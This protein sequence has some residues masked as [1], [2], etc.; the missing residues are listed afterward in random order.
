M[1]PCPPFFHLCCVLSV[2][3]VRQAARNIN[4]CKKQVKK[5]QHRFSCLED[6]FSDLHL[7]KVFF[8]FK[9]ESR[10]KKTLTRGRL[11]DERDVCVA[12]SPDETVFEDLWQ[13]DQ[14]SLLQKL[15]EM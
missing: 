1:M 14:M 2:F 7:P 6:F 12:W 3:F 4:G 9:K 5:S 15:P 8:F 13:G 10:E 11:K